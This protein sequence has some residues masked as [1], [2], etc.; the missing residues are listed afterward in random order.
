[1]FFAHGFW[2]ELKIF[3]SSALLSNMGATCFV[4][5]FAPPHCDT[6][7]DKKCQYAENLEFL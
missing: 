4:G 1:M 5:N 3:N 6:A 7:D 2:W